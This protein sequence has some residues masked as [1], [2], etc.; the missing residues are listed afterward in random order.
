[1]PLFYFSWLAMSGVQET[2]LGY[3]EKAFTKAFI[4]ANFIPDEKDLKR[5]SKENINE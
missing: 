1:M 2:N 5:Y 4:K 3:S